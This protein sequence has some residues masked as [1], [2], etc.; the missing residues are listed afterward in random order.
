MAP[1]EKSNQIE[2]NSKKSKKTNINIQ[3][4]EEKKRYLLYSVWSLFKKK[5]C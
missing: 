2:S 3:I 5:E 4:T 1:S